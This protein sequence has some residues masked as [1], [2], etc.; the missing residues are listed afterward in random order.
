ME[1]DPV[2]LK[3]NH[4]QKHTRAMARRIHD[5]RESGAYIKPKVLSN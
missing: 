3:T 4:S 1:H 5:E 2:N